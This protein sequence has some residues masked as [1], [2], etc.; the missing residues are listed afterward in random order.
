M[1]LMHLLCNQ[2]WKKVG[3]TYKLQMNPFLARKINEKEGKYPFAGNV[4]CRWYST[5]KY[6]IF[7]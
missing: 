2:L 7:Q 6:P 3:T 5:G 4:W 1:Q